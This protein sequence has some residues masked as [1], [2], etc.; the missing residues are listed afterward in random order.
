MALSHNSGL[1]QID[2]RRNKPNKGISR[3]SG[4][5]VSNKGK[6]SFQPDEFDGFLNTGVGK[7]STD[8]GFEQPGDSSNTGEWLHSENELNRKIRLDATK[9]NIYDFDT[10][11]EDKGIA[12]I[13]VK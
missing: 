11:K 13:L 4:A 7:I 8:P 10:D 3:P 5:F 2:S 1:R 12:D 6:I 9:P